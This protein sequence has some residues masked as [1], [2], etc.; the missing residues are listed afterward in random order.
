MEFTHQCSQNVI[1]ENSFVIVICEVGSCYILSQPKTYNP[2]AL[3]LKRTMT[4]D[5]TTTAA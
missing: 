3:T 2:P 5:K 1:R 4:P